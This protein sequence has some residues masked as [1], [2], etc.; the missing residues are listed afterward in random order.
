MHDHSAAQALDNSQDEISSME[1]RLDN[2]YMDGPGGHFNS[3]RKEILNKR[4]SISV[5]LTNVSD[6]EEEFSAKYGSISEI[7]QHFLNQEE[8]ISAI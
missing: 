2:A 5:Q 6:L 8:E 7:I 4:A 3:L 1:R